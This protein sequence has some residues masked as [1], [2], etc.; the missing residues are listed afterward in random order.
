MI[1]AELWAILSPAKPPAPHRIADADGIILVMDA[2]PTMRVEGNKIMPA[3]APE[4]A[5]K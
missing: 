4:E 1:L 5:G 2:L 3:G